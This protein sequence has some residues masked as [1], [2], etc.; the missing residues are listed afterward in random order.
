MVILMHQLLAA[1]RAT[2][3]ATVRPRVRTRR[4]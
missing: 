2:R 1:E 4:A 3:L